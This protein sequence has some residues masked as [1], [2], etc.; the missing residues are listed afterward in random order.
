MR[1]IFLIVCHKKT[2]ALIYNLEKFSKFENCHVIVHIDKKSHL[3]PS[4][5]VI[6]KNIHYYENPTVVKWGGF[7]QIQVTYNL[8]KYI[9]HMDYDYVSL[10]SGEDVFIRSQEA[11]NCFLKSN[12]LFDFVGFCR[13][14]GDLYNPID[15]VQYCY[16]FYFFNRDKSKIYSCLRRITFFMFSLGLFKNKATPYK[17]FCKGSNWFTI[18]KSTSSLI[19]DEVDNKKLL[20]FYKNSFCADEVFVQTIIYNNC[21][22]DSVYDFFNYDDN[23]MS[24]RYVDW[25]SGPDFPKVLTISDLE[26][27][28]PKD[29][30]FIRKIC[31]SVKVSELNKLFGL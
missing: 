15:R 16:P 21:M 8:L 27:E 2:P 23:R 20:D 1:L 17:R 4:D 3:L 30:F 5:L 13:S 14:D 7:S 22:L 26:S 19:V 24:L 18:R 10:M 31:S 6:S 29:V 12:N 28:F 9:D 11:F 25:K